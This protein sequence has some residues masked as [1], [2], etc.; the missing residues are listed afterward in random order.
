METLEEQEQEQS[1]TTIVE[2]S[3][4]KTN[5]SLPSEIIE[6]IFSRLPV[7]S[8]LRFRTLSKSWLSRISDP[9]FTNLHLTRAHRTALFIL[10]HDES[11][12]RHL[13]SAPHDGSRH[14][15]H[16]IPQPLLYCYGSPTCERVSISH[17]HEAL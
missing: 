11:S 4:K 1:T 16:H 13:L 10:A 12:K 5:M 14:S 8:I 15:S 2:R 17:V 6:D 3:T 9:S 7:K